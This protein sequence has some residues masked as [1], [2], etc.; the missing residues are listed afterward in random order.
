[1][2]CEYLFLAESA[3]KKNATTLSYEK[4]P[5]VCLEPTSQKSENERGRT[6]FCGGAGGM[7]ASASSGRGGEKEEQSLRFLRNA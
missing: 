7:V 3:C 5:T 6:V 1:M 4:Q 2:D